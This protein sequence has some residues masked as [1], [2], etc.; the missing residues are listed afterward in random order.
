MPIET[1]GLDIG[2]S[3]IKAVSVDRQKQPRLVN[4][5]ITPTGSVFNKILAGD[6]RSIVEAAD[7]LKSFLK[8]T[9]IKSTAVV[10]VIPDDKVFTKVLSLPYLKDK[11]LSNAVKWEAEQIIPQ[12]LDEVYLKYSV[13]RAEKGK[14]KGVLETIKESAVKDL[15]NK[16][17]QTQ[18]DVKE[19]ELLLVAVPKTLISNYITLINKIG[20]EPAGL[21]P[22]SIASIRSITVNDIYVPTMIVNLGYNKVSFYFAIENTLRFVRTINFALSSVLKIIKTELDLSENQA[23]E[24]LFTYGL[25]EKELSG[26]LRQLIMP[27]INII[28]DELNKSVSYVESKPELMANV[29]SKK[30]K[31]IIL[32]GGG[33]LIPDLLLYF[34]SES[35]IEIE[36]G[37]S[38]EGMD[39]SSIRDQKHLIK[40]SPIFAASAGAALKEY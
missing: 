5:S 37:N 30:V 38:F 34:V 32:T 24:Y 40:L 6:N 26:K 21:E 25:R 14:S 12:P 33:A 2:T 39:I 13:L 35:G 27:V 17:T 29:E 36:L 22:A 15:S 23:N 10:M 16:D 9:G 19:L 7:Y 3:F 4:Y 20:L 8:E 1:L 18:A 31:R 11:E 28:F